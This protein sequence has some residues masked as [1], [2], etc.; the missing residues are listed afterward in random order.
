[1]TVADHNDL[2]LRRR[3]CLYRATR[4]GIKEMDWLLGRYAE[5]VL[6]S[7]DAEAVAFWE[8]LVEL[9]DPQF[10]DWIMGHA[11]AEDAQ[12]TAVVTE[13]RRFHGME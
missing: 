4:R 12:V 9:P 5:A 6:P 10:Q 13:I 3:R 2:N 1:M 11:A 8:R 7:A